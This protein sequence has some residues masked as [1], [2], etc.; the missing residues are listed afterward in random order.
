MRHPLAFAVLAALIPSGCVVSIDAQG[1]DLVFDEIV[2]HLD[3]DTGSGDVHVVVD[4]TISSVQV[5]REVRFAGER[6]ELIALVEEGT[7]TLHT[8]C[9]ALQAVCEVS[10]EVRLP[11]ATS[12]R[13]DTGSGTIVADG[14]AAEIVASTGSGDIVLSDVSGD[15]EADTG[16]GSVE[17]LA[18]DV[19]SVEADTGSGSVTLDLVSVPERVWV[20]TG[21]GRVDLF[22]PAA[23]YDIRVDT[24]SGRTTIGEGIVQ[25]AGA[26]AVVRVDTGSGGVSIEAR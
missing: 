5:H 11:D 19:A 17:I 2:H 16:S 1:D 7:L 9:R 26:D 12:A 15:V 18:G 3:V 8:R 14:L 13:L 10:Y 20:D 4:P 23:A 25:D 24:G 22:L 21:S 6:P